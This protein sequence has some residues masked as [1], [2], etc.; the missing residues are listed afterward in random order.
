MAAIKIDDDASPVVGGA[1]TTTVHPASA[2]ASNGSSAYAAT[3]A[4]SG[5]LGPAFFPNGTNLDTC[6]NYNNIF[7]LVVPGRQVMLDFRYAAAA[8]AKRRSNFT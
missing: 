3:A 2:A 6:P 4:K 1:P 7:G 8:R 5:N